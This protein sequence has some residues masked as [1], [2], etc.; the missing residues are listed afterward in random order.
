MEMMENERKWPQRKNI[1]LRNYDYSLPGDYFV[2][3]V[4]QSRRCLFGK[5]ADDGLCLNEA[6]LL[7]EECYKEIGTVNEGV[8]SLDHVVMP[9]HFH[10]IIRLHS[11]SHSLS[12]IVR[13]LK[14]KTT[15]GYIHG[16]RQKGWKPFDGQLWQKGFYEHVIRRERVFDYIRNYIFQNPERWYYDKLNPNCSPIA[17]NISQAIKDLYG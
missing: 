16:V 1:R 9:N 12:E 4:T 14:S 5:V 13:V 2:T 17:D 10:C 3:I 6:G 15:V 11:G 7:I 8:E